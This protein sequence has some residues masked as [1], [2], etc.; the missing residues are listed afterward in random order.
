MSKR[1]KTGGS[2]FG[3]ALVSMLLF[4]AVVASGAQAMAWRLNGKTLAELGKTKAA[5]NM[6]GGTLTLEVPALG[7]TVECDSTSSSGY[8]VGEDDGN[9]NFKASGCSGSESC[10]AYPIEFAVDIGLAPGKT[11]GG[12]I[13]PIETLT[14]N[15]SLI[16]LEFYGE[17]CALSELEF[18][19]HSEEGSL[20]AEANKPKVLHNLT[21]LSS[22]QAVLMLGGNEAYVSLGG[23][24]EEHYA[25]PL[26]WLGA[27]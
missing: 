19:L 2:V 5:Y 23:S 13:K 11:E 1:R 7:V 10:Q 14:P 15:D 26:V 8:L 25:N 3:L 24:L 20:G 27:W 12:E 18:N 6:N 21:G 16:A 17:E 4:G 9:G 22:H